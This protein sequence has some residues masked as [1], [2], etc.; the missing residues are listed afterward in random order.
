MVVDPAR[1]SGLAANTARRAC[2]G[3]GERH[4]L[5]WIIPGNRGVLSIGIR[6]TGCAEVSLNFQDKRQIGRLTNVG[7]LP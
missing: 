1:R 4:A 3:A 7:G 6:R 5:R 2:R